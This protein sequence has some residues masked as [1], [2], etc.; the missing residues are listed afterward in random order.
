MLAPQ[1]VEHGHEGCAIG[2]EV[3]LGP[4]SRD[5]LPPAHQRIEVCR[6]RQFR[7]PRPPVE[8]EREL[9]QVVVVEV[10][11][12]HAHR[13]ASLSSHLQQGR[14]VVV[15]REERHLTADELCVGPG[16]SPLA[17][18]RHLLGDL[19]QRVRTVDA[20]LVRVAG[21]VARRARQVALR[22]H[23]VGSLATDREA[24]D[25]LVRRLHTVGQ[26]VP[27]LGHDGAT[28]RVDGAGDLVE[29]AEGAPGAAEES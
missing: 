28:F 23:A 3:G 18:V 25:E 2:V 21:V 17:Q 5:A 12:S 27:A 9:S 8:A 4:G 1:S 26:L 19:T 7:E 13:F 10:S 29:S 14:G 22:E 16:T 24:A 15:D 11:V 20:D 6:E